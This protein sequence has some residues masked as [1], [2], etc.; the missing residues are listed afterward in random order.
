MRKTWQEKMGDKDA[1]PKVVHLNAEGQRHWHAKTM[2]VP[3]PH[4]VDDYMRQVPKGKLIEVNDIR[5]CLADRFQTDIGC[6]MT[7]G[8]FTW[9][10]A[11][12]AANTAMAGQKS[13]T[14][15]WRTLKKGGE[16]NAKYPGGL[17]G[18]KRHLEA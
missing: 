10:A 8:I 6:P 3:T 12:A 14:P 18:H 1:K 15:Y 17:T 4:L 11:N 16:L 5:D 13:T 7:T 2:L 9:I